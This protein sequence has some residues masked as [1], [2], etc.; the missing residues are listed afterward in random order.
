MLTH[1][2]MSELE[3]E[4]SLEKSDL[5]IEQN[6]P[7]FHVGLPLSDNLFLFSFSW[8]EQ[9]SNA[10]NSGSVSKP[11]K[12][13]LLSGRKRQH[14]LIKG[15]KIHDKNAP[16]NILRKINVHYISFIKDA[17]NE[18]LNHCEYTEKFID[19]DYEEKRN[20]TK[21]KF[22]SLK[23]SNIGEILCQKVSRKFRKQSNQNLYKNKD[24]FDKVK[25]NKYVNIFLSNNYITLFK[26]V[27]YENKR[28]IKLDDF[29]FRFSENVKT[30]SNLL[31]EKFYDK[32]ELKI[33]VNEVIHKHYLKN[34]F[35]VEKI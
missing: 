2:I 6:I 28:D 3:D 19:I 24:I 14:Q 27:Y 20:I 15:V 31:S 34:Y 16:D 9:N 35:K 4:L 22:S 32:D 13:K 29:N 10:D 7:S 26:D 17:V 33:K 8:N 5:I 1:D 30:Y 21:K 23:K 18:L 11:E 25:T 12:M